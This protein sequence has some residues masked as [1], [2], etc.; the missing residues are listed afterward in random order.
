[1]KNKTIKYLLI[2]LILVLCECVFFRNVLGNSAMFGDRGDGRLTMLLTEHWWNFFQGKESFFELAMFF[3]D[4]NVLSYS[5][6][7]LGFGLIH[8][9]FRFFNWDM[10]LSF[11]YTL[12]LIHLLGTFS[13]FYLTYNKL[14]MS[15][16]GSLFATVA[17]CFSS[18]LSNHLGHTQLM[19]MSFL[20]VLS[21]LLCSIEQKF[22]HQLKYD[23]SVL[24]FI[25]CFVLLMYTSWYIA[26]FGVL[27]SA[28]LFVVYIALLKKYH[29]INFVLCWRRFKVLLLRLILYSCW[30]LLLLLPFI[31]SYIPTFISS[32]GWSYWDSSN[33]LP[34]FADLI[35]VGEHN[36]LMGNI[37]SLMGLAYRRYSSEVQE[38]FSIVL[39]VLFMGLFVFFKRSKINKSDINYQTLFIYSVFWSIIVS[40]LL[41]VRLSANGVSLWAVVRL[42][43]PGATSIRAIARLMLWLSFPMSIVCGYVFDKYLFIRHKTFLFSILLVFLV[44]SNI[45]IFAIPSS[46]TAA[47]EREFL[48]H[49]TPPA[50]NAKAFYLVDLVNKPEAPNQYALDAFEIANHF[51]IK[52]L[53]GYSGK[54]PIDYHITYYNG[55]IKGI[56]EW[57]QK[58]DLEDVF[59]YDRGRNIWMPHGQFQQEEIPSQ[60][61]ER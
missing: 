34:E 38:G 20:P 4:Q 55:E 44:Y 41:I 3:P 61:M 43:F 10:F 27:F 37:L 1:M 53:N 35:N 52:T 16:L 17:F 32:N 9:F 50:Q 12:V 60:K 23:S 13:M 33:Y 15:V 2:V 30:T 59:V 31:C 19:A 51:N 14:K 26:F 29:L 54:A 11:K 49:I 47:Q 57:I 24:L 46:W 22:T 58:N 18:T 40:F 28:I 42:L 36:I 5:D 45:G 25:A 48:E 7:L 21:I 39:L 6:M 8:S 56:N